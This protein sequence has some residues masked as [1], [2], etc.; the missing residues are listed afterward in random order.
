MPC[1]DANDVVR[2]L[3]GGATAD[4]EDHIDACEDCRALVTE[5][6]RSLDPVTDAT[7]TDDLA[8]G[9]RDDLDDIHAW[10]L[11]S[12]AELVARGARVGRYVVLDPIGAGAMGVVY[13]A[14][15]PELDR[16][17]A[18]KLLRVLGDAS[19]GED[20][21]AR[22]VREA[23]S[24]ARVA[25]PNVVAV[26][27]AS[28]YGEHV[29]VAM[30]L[31]DGAD[32]DAWLLRVPRTWR[33]IARVFLAA[34]RGLAAAH[35]AGVIH[36]DVKAANILVG[37]DDRVR[38]TDFGLA[39]DSEA[40][41]DTVA[42]T[43]AYMSP[44]VRAGAPAD[45]RSDQ[46]SLALA[47]Q[48]A[49]HGHRNARDERARDPRS[50]API[51]VRDERARDPRS[52]ARTDAPIDAPIDVRDERAR[53]PRIHARIDAPRAVRRV[54]ARALAA[55]P[56]DRYASMAA[57]CAD[58]E[59][60]IA[61]RSRV[62]LLVAAGAAV[63][64]S[65]TIAA[66]AMR[67][68][69][70]PACSLAAERLA[71]VWDAPAKARLQR[72]FLATGHPL[73]AETWPRVEATLNDVATAWSTVYDDACAATHARHE[74]SA[75]LLDLRM[76]CLSTELARLRAVT[77]QLAVADKAF[78][79]RA[80]GAVDIGDRLARCSDVVA[81]RASPLPQTPAARARDAAATSVLAYAEAISLRAKFAPAITLANAV[82]G[83]ARAVGDRRLEADALRS[84][85]ESKWRAGDYA[86][87]LATLHE[88]VDAAKRAT[89]AD[90]EAGALLDLV[91]VLVEQGTYGEAM[92]VARL[93]ESTIRATG[94]D[95]R[96][97]KLLGNRGAIH[98]LQGDFASARADYEQALELFEKAFGPSDRRVG[99]TVMNLAMLAAETDSPEAL[100][101]Y[102]RA[103][104]IHERA[105]GPRHPEVALTLANR[106]IAL[107]N[108]GRFD[109]A[110]RDLER[111]LAIRT[112]V[113]GRDHRDTIGT[114]Q[115]MALV[116]EERGDVTRA[117]AVQ[118]RV[119][120][121]LGA[122]IAADHPMRAN[123]LTAIGRAL[124][125]LGK[126]ADA[127]AP[128]EQAIAAFDKASVAGAAPASARFALARAIW[129]TRGDRTRARTLATAALAA[130]EDAEQRDEIRAWLATHGGA[131]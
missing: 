47:L 106:A 77:D 96:L 21:R 40:T 87:A 19:R 54:L 39:I 76:A 28:T 10:E 44:E 104:A 116:A 65:A 53:D 107:A 16:D 112:E 1:L 63:L 93:A 29:Y 129:E 22:L 115:T 43:P 31:V 130:H 3:D 59:R 33:E 94:D 89:A 113:L 72:A 92:Q 122:S 26:Y 88:A 52:D 98:Y 41:D 102:A 35:A 4:D 6:G 109:D 27:D 71:G 70:A 49:L 37:A 30:E 8:R 78:V 50:D 128:L 25:H 2:F 62:P 101:L 34:A 57:L 45:E 118:R 99:Q 38:I 42:G 18:L 11:A 126:H 111:A 32:A 124:V 114:L 66:V 121:R 69:E 17:V 75:E 110:D 86:G 68:S 79:R 48:Q 14:Y 117:L 61:P 125:A 15:D 123:T 100:P 84:A 80:L 7:T 5:I 119:L 13:R 73:A 95:P 64:A 36:R 51:D 108:A 74:Q 85:G 91:A 131:R 90:L 81:L 23:Q 55:A 58:L 105:L 97:A 127:I 56:G 120:E 103:L 24:L 60:A 12:G 83:E 46:Y 20:A 9:S 67:A 82:A